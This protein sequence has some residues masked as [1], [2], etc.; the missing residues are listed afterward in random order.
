[1]TEK[2]KSNPNFLWF[3]MVSLSEVNQ[4]LSSE[5]AF[6]KSILIGSGPLFLI[7]KSHEIGRLV[8]RILL[9]LN[10][11]GDI[12]IWSILNVTFKDQISFEKL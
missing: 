6:V 7:E 1:M 11:G 10:S 9:K 3:L 5:D 2:N 8:R 12:V 4:N